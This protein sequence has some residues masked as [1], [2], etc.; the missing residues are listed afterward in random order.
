MI[1]QRRVILL[2]I[3][4]NPKLMAPRRDLT[5]DETE[6]VV[7]WAAAKGVHPANG[8]NHPAIGHPK[9]KVL[10]PPQSGQVL[11][12]GSLMPFSYEKITTWIRSR[13]SSL[14]RTRLTCERIVDS[15]TIRASAIS[16]FDKPWAR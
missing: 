6:Q 4:G 16:R 13:R 10:A 12:R 14:F 3:P 15:S 9:L 2:V 1:V 7:A 8:V 11:L 5:L